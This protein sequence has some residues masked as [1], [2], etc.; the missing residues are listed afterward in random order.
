MGT[1]LRGAATLN[2]KTVP[3]TLK[4]EPIHD[5]QVTS[6]VTLYGPIDGQP[7]IAHISYVTPN[8]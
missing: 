8:E 4:V 1:S 5:G 7:F 3:F 6:G 2:G